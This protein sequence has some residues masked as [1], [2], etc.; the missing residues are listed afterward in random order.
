MILNYL[1][2][3][4]KAVENKLYIIALTSALALPDICACLESSNPNDNSG[5]RKRYK[6]WYIKNAQN[7]CLLDAESCYKYRCSMV[8]SNNSLID[9][10]CE[11][12]AFFLPPVNTTFNNCDVKITFKNSSGDDVI[13]IAKNVKK[14]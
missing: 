9:T 4:E 14:A 1:S 11:K 2:E 7:R 3:I 12:V 5:V 13:E 6:K 10:A 8:H